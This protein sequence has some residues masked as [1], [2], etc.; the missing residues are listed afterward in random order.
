M[1]E[2][3][4]FLRSAG[5]IALAIFA[6]AF[7]DGRL[8]GALTVLMFLVTLG[9]TLQ[10]R[11][12][13][14]LSCFILFPILQTLNPLVFQFSYVGS[15]VNRISMFVLSFVIV[16]SAT[17]SKGN[18]RLSLGTLWLYLLLAVVSSAQGYYPQISY[19]KLA[20]FTAFLVGIWLGTRNL[21]NSPKDL[22]VLRVFIMGVCLFLIL[23][24][25]ALLPFPGYAYLNLRSAVVSGG[26]AQA[27]AEYAEMMASGS[28][29]SLFAGVTNQ[30]QCLGPMLAAA[31][32]WILCDMLFILKRIEKYRA[33]IALSGLVLMF[34]THSRTSL[35]AFMA[36]CFVMVFFVLKRIRM[37]PHARRRVVSGV[38]FS[39][40]LFV[41]WVIQA[42]IRHGEMTKW[43]MKYQS[44]SSQSLVEGMTYSRQGLIEQNWNDFHYNE[45]LGCGFQVAWTHPLIYAG[46]GG[47][48]LS[49]PIEKGV[50]PLMVLGEGG[51]VGAFA[52][53]IFLI[54]FYSGCIRSRHYVSMLLFTVLLASNMGEADFFSP[55]GIGG[56]KWVLCVVGGFVIDTMLLYQQKIQRRIPI[57]AGHGPMPRW[58]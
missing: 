48:I 53:A 49:A 50:L 2:D 7:L 5:W 47:L 31:V 13:I 46:K 19:L 39:I 30:S 23:G 41:C 15:V 32:I 28:G 27:E 35:V 12:G 21:Q 52:F 57:V 37:S 29:I 51:V 33:I 22:F 4:K 14:A 16:V 38:Y 45:F 40:I 44:D 58:R 24:S 17:R 56:A 25:A 18:N 1:R 54:A 34:M 55:G 3:H 20:N 42:E 36:G 9:A 6:V 11:R 43:L 8:Q 10:N 26:I